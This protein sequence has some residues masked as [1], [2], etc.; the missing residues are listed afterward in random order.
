M[1]ALAYGTLIVLIIPLIIYSGGFTAIKEPLVLLFNYE[2]TNGV[3]TE[4]ETY[5]FRSSRN[6]SQGNRGGGATVWKRLPYL[7][8]E[9]GEGSEAY[10][11]PLPIFGDD[12]CENHLDRQ[13]TIVK[14][15]SDSSRSRILDMGLW[16]PIIHILNLILCTYI[17]LYHTRYILYF[18]GGYGALVSVSYL[19]TLT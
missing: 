2:L 7:V 11:S 18:I 12:W 4:C 17:G 10:G 16:L 13:V 5:T 8:A 15:T 9:M 6:S 1:K 19:V 3:T 14:S